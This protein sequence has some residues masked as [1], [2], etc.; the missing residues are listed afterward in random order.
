[1][2]CGWGAPTPQQREWHLRAPTLEPHRVVFVRV[3]G[4][5]FE[6]HSPEQIRAA[7]EYYARKLRPTSRLAVHMLDY[8]G[9]QGETQRWF[10]RLPLYLR[11]EPRR[12]R[13]VSALEEA[14]RR[15]AAG[16]A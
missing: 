5:T 11:E 1:M 15:A 12:R 8:G 14:L 9:D 16:E 7:L 2:N 4:F 13:V 6:F 10:E 3:A